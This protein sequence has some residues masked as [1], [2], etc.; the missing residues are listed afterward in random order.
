MAA[1]TFQTLTIASGDIFDCM[2]ISQLLPYTLFKQFNALIFFFIKP[3]SFLYKRRG[4]IRLL[5]Q[6]ES[7]DRPP[8]ILQ[9]LFV[10][11]SIAQ[12]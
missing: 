9:F 12:E 5:L 2:T 7:E 1:V 3:K 11:S 4:Q 8:A 10:F 6:N